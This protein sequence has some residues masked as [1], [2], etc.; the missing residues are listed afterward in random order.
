MLGK[1]LLKSHFC[2][3][4][5]QSVTTWQI[6]KNKSVF[7][8]GVGKK[9]LVITLVSIILL[10]SPIVCMGLGYFSIS[11]MSHILSDFSKAG[12]VVSEYFQTKL[13]KLL[14]QSASNHKDISGA[15]QL[16][17][18]S[19]SQEPPGTIAK[20][21]GNA[22]F[23]LMDTSIGVSPP[24]QSTIFEQCLHCVKQEMSIISDNDFSEC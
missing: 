1:G 14:Q 8:K 23:S 12:L 2:R 11:N 16:I 5:D 15:V 3:P 19:D 24:I 22:H 20:Q 9:L 21:S 6:T 10:Q 7:P 4:T 18:T 17:S 13:K